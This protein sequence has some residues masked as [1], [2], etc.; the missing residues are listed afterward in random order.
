MAIN[1]FIAFSLSRETTFSPLIGN[2]LSSFF[3]LIQNLIKRFVLKAV[4]QI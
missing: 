2:F 3:F 4:L 1:T